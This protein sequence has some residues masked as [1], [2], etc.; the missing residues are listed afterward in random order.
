[1]NIPKDNLES[2]LY[3]MSGALNPE[4]WEALTA[5]VVDFG[6]ELIVGD[7]A[8]VAAQT[9]NTV[10]LDDMLEYARGSGDTDLRINRNQVSARLLWQRSQQL[11]AAKQAQKYGTDLLVS[12]QGKDNIPL[13]VK[14]PLQYLEVPFLDMPTIKTSEE[15]LDWSTELDYL[16]VSSL[17]K[18][19]AR[20]RNY[21]RKSFEHLGIGIRKVR[22]DFLSEFTDH[23]IAN[24]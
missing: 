23:V 21:P 9:V 3:V 17:K 7:T 1:M 22:A 14:S 10:T 4:S 16:T 2:R 8:S 24:S 20:Y 6:A 5:S 11:Y 15:W 18:Q 12:A 19:V 13:P